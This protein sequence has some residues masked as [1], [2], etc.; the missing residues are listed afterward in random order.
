MPHTPIGWDGWKV[1]SMTIGR[2][3]MSFAS[4]RISPS[5]CRYTVTASEPGWNVIVMEHG[6]GK[7]CPVD[8]EISL[9]MGD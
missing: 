3:Q 7:A 6:A 9:V 1:E 5:Q 2:A 8:G 4:E